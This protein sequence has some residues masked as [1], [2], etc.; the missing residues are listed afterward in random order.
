MHGRE[1]WVTDGNANGTELVA[2]LNPGAPDS[3]PVSLSAGTDS[4][5]FGANDGVHG[6]EPFK[7]T[8]HLDTT[9]PVIT[10]HD[11]TANATSPTG[12][13]VTYMVTAT[14]D[15]DPSPTVTCSPDSGSTFGIGDTLVECTATDAAG[16]HASASFNVHVKDASEQLADLAEAVDELGPG[17][18]LTDKLDDARAA[19]DR[20]DT[21][22]ACSVLNAFINQVRASSARTIAPDTANSLIEDATRIRAVLGC[23]Q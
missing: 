20:D 11:V 15:T 23:T 4:L 10:A 19:L 12:A 9:P 8:V 17:T 5:F 3:A 13:V 18:S 14:D 1:L 7:L 2:D 22:D 6:W 21:A 16:N